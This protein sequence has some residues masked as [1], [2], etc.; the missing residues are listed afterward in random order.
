M[1]TTINEALKIMNGHDWYYPME[2]YN[3]IAN[4]NAA[5]AS[6]RRFVAKVNEIADSTIREALRNLWIEN[7]NEARAE[8][9][10]K[11][12]EGFAE[13][14]ESLMKVIAA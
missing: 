12:T 9:N 5:K 4:S 13:R 1:E 3:Y 14:K 6:M 10:G 11:S 8:M 7:Y 2:D